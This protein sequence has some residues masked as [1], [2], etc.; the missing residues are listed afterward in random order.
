[1]AARPAEIAGLAGKGKIAPGYDADLV[2]FAPDDS[3]VVTERL[4]QHRHKLTPYAGRTLHGVVRQTWLRGEP[5][6]A[7]RP[8]GRLL[9][10][11][12]AAA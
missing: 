8:A 2:A 7:A 6:S 4:L 11:E 12:G 1:M 9:A 10:R 5:V 3:F